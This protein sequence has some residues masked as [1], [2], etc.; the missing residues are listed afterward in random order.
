MA[1]G[2]NTSENEEFLEVVQLMTAAGHATR[3]GEILRMA[4]QGDK[5]DYQMASNALANLTRQELYS[6]YPHLLAYT[7]NGPDCYDLAMILGGF[8]MLLTSLSC[9]SHLPPNPSPSPRL[10][11][12]KGRKGF[13]AAD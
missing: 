7:K 11:L 5:P 1:K 13:S 10:V 9:R 8:R 3:A 12:G 4:L 2:D 6:I